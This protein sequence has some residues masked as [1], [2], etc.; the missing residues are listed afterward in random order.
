MLACRVPV[1]DAPELRTVNVTATAPF[2]PCGSGPK[3]WLSGLMLSLPGAIPVPVSEALAEVPGVAVTVSVPFLTPVA[4]GVNRTVIMQLL[5]AGIAA[6]HPFEPAG[7]AN[8]PASPASTPAT[9]TIGIPV[10]PPP[11]FDTTNVADAL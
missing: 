5:A 7:I 4:V 11:G 8:C 10:A 9:E 2:V 6:E 3:S 1:G